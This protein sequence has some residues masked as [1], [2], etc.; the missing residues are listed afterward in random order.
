MHR[1]LRW[2]AI[3]YLLRLLLPASLQRTP[4]VE[5]ST[6]F[7]QSVAI[8]YSLGTGR[9]RRVRITVMKSSTH[10][11]HEREQSNSIRQPPR[12]T[13]TAVKD[14]RSSNRADPKVV[15]AKTDIGKPNALRVNCSTDCYHPQG[16]S[17]LFMAAG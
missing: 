12:N 17:A 15:P 1:Y 7:G 3:G 9:Q 5:R 14:L 2:H 8:V 13:S 16:E 4:S 11:E 6:V 10:I